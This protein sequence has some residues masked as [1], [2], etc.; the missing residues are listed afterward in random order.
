MPW[1]NIV[2]TYLGSTCN[3]NPLAT[4]EQVTQACPGIQD[5]DVVRLHQDNGRNEGSYVFD[6]SNELQ[7]LTPMVGGFGRVPM[8]WS[9]NRVQEPFFFVDS[10][11]Y[12]PEVLYVDWA[13]MAHRFGSQPHNGDP[14]ILRVGN[15]LVLAA[16]IQQPGWFDPIDVDPTEADGELCENTFIIVE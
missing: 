11:E 6:D 7:P 15:Y 4:R 9:L 16:V 12:E 13:D 3:N 10:L 8:Q 5:G 14:N 1:S 2:N